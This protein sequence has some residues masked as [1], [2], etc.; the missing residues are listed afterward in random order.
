M[1]RSI[2][3]TNVLMYSRDVNEPAKRA[4]AIEVIDQLG[5]CGDLVLTAQILNEFSAATLRRGTPIADVRAAVESWRDL[6]EVLPLQPAATTVALD[7]VNR[8]RLSFWDALIW[9][10]ARD[11]QVKTVISEDFQ[12]GREIDGVAFVDPFRDPPRASSTPSES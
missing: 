3:D 10:T 8:H 11:A 7:A 5:A 2:V 6:A 12:H 9:A 1:A 4:R